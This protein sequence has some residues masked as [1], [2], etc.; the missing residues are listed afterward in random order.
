MS[1]LILNCLLPFVRP[2]RT[3]SV[4]EAQNMSTADYL[5]AATQTSFLTFNSAPSIV[6]DQ[7]VRQSLVSVFEQQAQKN[8]SAPSIQQLFN[9]AREACAVDHDKDV[10]TWLETLLNA[11]NHGN[12][13]NHGNGG[14]V[15]TPPPV[16]HPTTNNNNQGGSNIFINPIFF[17]SE[18]SFKQLVKTLDGAQKSLDICVYTITD[19]HLANAIIRAHE[20]GVKV[21]IIS[22]SEKADDLGSDVN[23]LRDNNDISTRVDKSKSFMHHKFAVIDDQLVI[24]GSYNWTKG[25]RFDNRENLTLTNSPKAIQGFKGEFERLWAEFA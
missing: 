5:D 17:P 13:G 14:H 4:Q 18:E 19:D 25:A 23:R 15:V 7:T 16:T 24:N 20:R 22:D 1:G 9:A 2:P 3:V 11:S 21:R 8:G 10:I 6:N 12:Q